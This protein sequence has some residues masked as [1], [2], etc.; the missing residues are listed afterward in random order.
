MFND[1]MFFY[2]VGVEVGVGS[3]MVFFNEVEGVLVIVNKWLMIDVLCGVWGFN[4]FVVI[5]FIGIFE[6]IE[7]GIGDL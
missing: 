3:V 5:D 1:Y 2:Q 4:G 7:Y 6:M